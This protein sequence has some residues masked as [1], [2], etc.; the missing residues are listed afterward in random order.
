MDSPNDTDSESTTTPF[1]LK[2]F[3]RNGTFHRFVHPIPTL[4]SL[5]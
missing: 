2:L 4:S 1:L 5:Y 3:Y